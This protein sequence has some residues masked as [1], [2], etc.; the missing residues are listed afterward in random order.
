MICKDL[1][2]RPFHLPCSYRKGHSFLL[3][4]NDCQ[5]YFTCFQEF[6]C[7]T[8][9]STAMQI[10]HYCFYLNFLLYQ[11]C[12]H[13][14]HHF[15][16][17]IFGIISILVPFDPNKRY[18]YLQILGGKA[19]LEHLQDPEPLPGRATSS[20]NLYVHFREQRFRSRPVPCACEPDFQE[21]KFN[22]IFCGINT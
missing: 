1:N 17:L 5:L 18:I 6:I 7:F 22:L 3:Q 13:S 16:E 20:F 4:E 12:L 8:V 2:N 15:P 21:G 14:L 19:F 9:T 11:M 10:L